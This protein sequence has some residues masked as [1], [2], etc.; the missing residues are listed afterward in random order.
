LT[1]IKKSDVDLSIISIIIGEKALG[2]KG[3]QFLCSRKLSHVTHL[4]LGKKIDIKVITKYLKRVYFT[5]PEPTLPIG[6]D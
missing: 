6:V 1:A 3:V 4:S 2:D 5:S